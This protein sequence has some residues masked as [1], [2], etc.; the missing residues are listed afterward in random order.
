MSVLD[1]MNGKMQFE[2]LLNLPLPFLDDIY[3]AQ[4][5]Y[6]KDKKKAEEDSMKAAEASARLQ[7]SNKRKGRK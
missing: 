6:L 5:K 1:L 2:Y 7:A 4:V 3:T